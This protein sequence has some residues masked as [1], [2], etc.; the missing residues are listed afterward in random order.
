MERR[1]RVGLSD[2]IW[3]NN[4]AVPPGT[5]DRLTISPN[6]SPKT[7][8]TA[9]FRNL[10][11]QEHRFD[12]SGTTVHME[13]KPHTFKE[14]PASRDLLQNPQS[15]LRIL[16]FRGGVYPPYNYSCRDFINT[17][18]TVGVKGKSEVIGHSQ[19][20]RAGI[21]GFCIESAGIKAILPA[22]LLRCIIGNSQTCTF[23][24]KDPESDEIRRSTYQIAKTR[25]TTVTD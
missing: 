20:Q 6:S 15:T 9:I 25:V 7:G 19:L 23:F 8:S 13:Y 4:R 3:I 17:P 18:K 10:R 11:L 22:S 12:L 14:R 16:S 2:K 1:Y 5:Y 21:R 24:W